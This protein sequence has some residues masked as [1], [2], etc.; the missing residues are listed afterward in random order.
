MLS[1]PIAGSSPGRIR[2]PIVGIVLTAL[3]RAR[4]ARGDTVVQGAQ[5]PLQG[6]VGLDQAHELV[7]EVLDPLLCDPR[8]FRPAHGALIPAFYLTFPTIGGRSMGLVETC[9]ERRWAPVA[10][11][12]V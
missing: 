12:R 4:Q 2:S 5:A 8:R 1:N 11:R 3:S 9:L 6:Q 7:R 10:E